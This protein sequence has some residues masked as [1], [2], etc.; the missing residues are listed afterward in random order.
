VSKRSIIVVGAGIGG[1]SAA[2]WLTKRGHDVEV[3]EAADRPGGRMQLL[4]RN[5]D[6]VDV[7]AQFF[8]SSY[9]NAL[10]FMDELGLRANRRSISAG[11]RFSRPDGS[12]FVLRH[13]WDFP[14]LLGPGG[15]A[16]LMAF[17]LRYLV[18]GKRFPM[19]QIV[20]SI[21]AYDGVSV[22]EIMRASHP[23]HL[24]YI[25]RPV[26]F[27]ETVGY[28]EHTSLY[29][30]IHQFRLTLYTRFVALTGGVSSLTDAL[31][32]RVPVRY[33]APVR[34]VIWEGARATGVELTDGTA[35][36]AD[37]VI[38]A[39]TPDAAAR[40]LPDEMDEQR[41][42]LASF[43]Q[44][45]IPLPVF[46]LDRP[47]NPE[48]CFY[49][50]DPSEDRS[51]NMAVDQTA[52]VPEMVPSGKAIVS[53]WA[54]Y[55]KTEKLFGQP[56]QSLIETALGDMERLI[57][58]FTGWVEDVALVRHQW[59]NAIYPPGQY[60]RVIDFRAGAEALEGVSFVGSPY[61]GVHMEAAILTA[62]RAV[63]RVERSAGR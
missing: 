46:F 61:G 21:P 35:R 6:R 54:A 15:S 55:P 4:E 60:Q 7:G 29:H 33:E 26:C 20:R 30:Y 59:G 16:S 62:K 58:G 18:F 52:R 28:P 63:L 48:V 1:L 50:G 12:E 56:D 23:R 49:F 53:A 14:R 27:G 19:S 13:D 2:H 42:F 40:I 32:R 9:K 22:A 51:F 57:P 10:R 45:P 39:T 3:L 43:P 31:A 8:H 34:G 17:A 47:L 24:D 44:T 38:V 5:G 41:G 37:H 25:V 36:K 11:T